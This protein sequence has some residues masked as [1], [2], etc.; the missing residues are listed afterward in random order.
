MLAATSNL[1]THL[2]PKE[3]DTNDTDTNKTGFLQ[4]RD[5][6]LRMYD[7]NYRWSP[8]VYDVRG[9]LGLDEDE[10]KARA[11]VGYPEGDLRAGDRAPDA[12]ALVSSNDSET[13]LFSIF[14]PYYHTILIFATGT[15]TTEAEDIVKVAKTYPEGTVRTIILGRN[16]IPSVVADAEAYYDKEGYAY[17]AYHVPEDVLTIVVVRPDSYVGCFAH[18]A[19]AVQ[20]YF[21]RI[22]ASAD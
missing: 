14:K 21:S 18:D 15:A 20:T 2:V 4:W 17:K 16:G 5:Q 8:I 13:A 10:L 22:F 3:S 7:I 1:Y 19:Q 11:Y 9:T 6:S 12:P